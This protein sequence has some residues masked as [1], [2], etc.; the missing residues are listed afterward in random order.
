MTFVETPVPEI[1]IDVMP[2]DPFL[3]SSEMPKPDTPYTYTGEGVEPTWADV[4]STAEKDYIRKT[5]TQGD[6][7]ADPFFRYAQNVGRAALGESLKAAGSFITRTYDDLLRSVNLLDD[8]TDYRFTDLAGRINNVIRRVNGMSATVSAI[9]NYVLPLVRLELNEI[10]HDYPIAIQYGIALERDWE[11]HHVF[12]PLYAEILKV[13]PAI[14]ASAAHTTQVAH[15]DAAAQVA[16]LATAVG[17]TVAGLRTRLATLEAESDDCVKPMCQ[18]MGPKT[19]L[20]KLLKGLALAGELAALAEL[21]NLTEAQLAA[22]LTSVGRKA[23][24][25]IGFLESHF[26]GGGE[27]IAATVTHAIA[28]GI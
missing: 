25:Y 10:K 4:F 17:V 9:V 11:L 20:G 24:D 16:T 2:D 21:A 14:N 19:D 3:W 8:V 5:P 1:P 27:T 18:T 12:A 6:Q 15:D 26:I 23:A 22:V 28:S 13:Q 7:T